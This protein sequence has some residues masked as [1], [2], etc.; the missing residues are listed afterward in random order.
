M[1]EIEMNVSLGRFARSGIEERLGCEVAVGVHGALRHYAELL[2]AGHAPPEFPGFLAEQLAETPPERF[3][4]SVDS[5]LERTL[6]LEAHRA[7]DVT[8]E[9]LAGHAVLVYLADLDRVC[10]VRA[11]PAPARPR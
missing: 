4:V 2:R 9:Q 8:M 5:E 1:Q 3:E 7:Q 10:Q 11:R 6:E